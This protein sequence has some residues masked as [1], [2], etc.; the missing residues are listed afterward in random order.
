M[1]EVVEGLSGAIVEGPWVCDYL[2]PVLS[3]N[4]W[5]KRV[6]MK[7]VNFD[8]NDLQ[9]RT[10]TLSNLTRGV[11][12]PLQNALRF[13]AAEPSNLDIS[14]SECF[15]KLRYLSH[16]PDIMHRVSEDK[17]LYISFSRSDTS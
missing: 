9:R 17:L 15:H 11:L 16:V 13:C 2:W 3:H 10:I 14:P 5:A 12:Y 4:C 8:E 1:N 6:R 7:Y